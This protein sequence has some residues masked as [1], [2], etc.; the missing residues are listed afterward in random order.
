LALRYLLRHPE[1]RGAE[2]PLSSQGGFSRF[3]G[4]TAEPHDLTQRL[5]GRRGA[6]DHRERRLW[7]V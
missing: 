7:I 3:T 6:E 2:G 5:R 4:G 1:A